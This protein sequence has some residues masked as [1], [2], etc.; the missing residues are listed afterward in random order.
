MATRS[1]KRDT[2]GRFATTDGPRKGNKKRLSA[3]SLQALKASDAYKAAKQQ[4]AAQKADAAVER[5]TD[6]LS[7]AERV[8]RNAKKD[9]TDHALETA[10]AD[11][12]AALK[13]YAAAL[14]RRSK[15]G[16]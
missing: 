5:A 11:R 6:N 9:G 1:Y 14:Q 8:Y 10:A 2:R 16:Q 13:Q 7:F 4:Q 3:E 15:A 12:L